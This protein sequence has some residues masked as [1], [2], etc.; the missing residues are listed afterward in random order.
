MGGEPTFA[1]ARANG[2]VAPIAAIQYPRRSMPEQLRGDG[3]ALGEACDSSLLQSSISDNLSTVVDEPGK[4]RLNSRRAFDAMHLC[5][6][7][8]ARPDD[9]DRNQAWRRSDETEV[10]MTKFERIIPILVYDDIPSAHD[11]LV[12]AF[13]F[14]FR[15][16]S[17]HA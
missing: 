16:R 4:R 2:K 10:S 11:F 5:H 17:T 3:G 8:S 7:Q 6:L 15:W 13:G 12:D 9:R 14:V 1:E